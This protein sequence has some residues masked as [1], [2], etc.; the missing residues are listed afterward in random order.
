MYAALILVYKILF[1]F[2]ECEKW[3]IFTPWSQVQLPDQRYV[4][5]NQRMIAQLSSLVAI[6]T[7]EIIYQLIAQIFP[8]YVILL[9]LFRVLTC[10]NSATW[11]SNNPRHFT[12]NGRIKVQFVSICISLLWNIIMHFCCIFLHFMQHVR[13]L[14]ALCCLNEW[15]NEWINQSINQSKRKSYRH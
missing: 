2:A 13:G 1:W 14:L 8:A 4:L 12:Y 7:C 5:H 6:L 9:A 3:C 11:T 15:M 10:W